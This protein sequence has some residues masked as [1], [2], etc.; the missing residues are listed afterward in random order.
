LLAVLMAGCNGERGTLI[1][2][3]ADMG[4]HYMI[5]IE[6]RDVCNKKDAIVFY[7]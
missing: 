3:C 7:R 6:G 1:A 4:G 2:R 5:G